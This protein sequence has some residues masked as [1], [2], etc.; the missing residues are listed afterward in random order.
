M[1]ARPIGVSPVLR[2]QGPSNCPKHVYIAYLRPCTPSP[3]RALR[4]GGQRTH[5]RTRGY[6]RSLGP[7][8]GPSGPY[9]RGTSLV[10]FRDTPTSNY[11]GQS[12]FPFLHTRTIGREEMD[13][14]SSTLPS[15]VQGKASSDGTLSFGH[16]RRNQPRNRW[17][18]L[19]PPK[20]SK[21][22]K[23]GRQSTQASYP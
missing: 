3:L 16:T 9:T 2:F 5:C 19:S 14:R 6:F 12:P 8:R 1:D 21:P 23:D 15:H 13:E 17:C 7:T 10:Y 22:L 20:L 11:E 18:W 4:G